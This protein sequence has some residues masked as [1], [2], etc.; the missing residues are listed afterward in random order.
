MSKFLDF[1]FHKNSRNISLG[2]CIS[3]KHLLNIC[4]SG[5]FL[6]PIF[7]SQTVVLSFLLG[8]SEILVFVYWYLVF[9]LVLVLVFGIFGIWY[10]Y[11]VFGIFGIWY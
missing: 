3:I 10:W 6:Y 8:K 11:L 7:F 4:L 5:I 9:V 1:D 2:F